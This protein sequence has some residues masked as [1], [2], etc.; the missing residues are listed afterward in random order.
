MLTLHVLL[1]SKFILKSPAQE[2]LFGRPSSISKEYLYCIC[3]VSITVVIN[4]KCEKDI[5]D[6]ICH[7]QQR[8][9][10]QWQ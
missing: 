10:Y 6:S 3:K 8:F 9:L 4:Q 1:V 2:S 7:C 5:C